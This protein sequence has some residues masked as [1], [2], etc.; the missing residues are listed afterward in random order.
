[1]RRSRSHP[2]ARATQLAR[3]RFEETS[4][5][6]QPPIA[7]AFVSACSWM[8]R[9]WPLRQGEGKAGRSNTFSAT[10]AAPGQGTCSSRVGRSCVIISV[11]RPFVPPLFFT[12]IMF[13]GQK[14]SVCH[15]SY[16]DDIARGGLLFVWKVFDRPPEG[17]RSSSGSGSMLSEMSFLGGTLPSLQSETCNSGACHPLCS[18]RS[19]MMSSRRFSLA[20]KTRRRCSRC[21]VAL[22]RRCFASAV[23]CIPVVAK[24]HGLPD[25][26]STLSSNVLQ[27]FRLKYPFLKTHRLTRVSRKRHFVPV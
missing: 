16:C 17:I 7:D 25:G 15:R 1:M 9:T 3:L 13:V 5:R 27:W 22:G 8:L 12:P 20:P 2:G 4:A 18:F 21:R 10:R 23:P 14:G 6:T 19:K 24:P 26:A 11:G